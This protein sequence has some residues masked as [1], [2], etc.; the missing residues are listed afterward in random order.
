VVSFETGSWKNRDSIILFCHGLT[1]LLM[2]KQ[3]LAILLLICLLFF[4]T[5]S[6]AQKHT[7]V[8]CRYHQDSIKEDSFNFQLWKI[9]GSHSFG[10]SYAYPGKFVSFNKKKD[11]S[12]TIYDY[13]VKDTTCAFVADG[14]GHEIIAIPGDTM[15]MN[16]NGKERKLV[17]NKY[18]VPWFHNLT[19]EG[20]NR[21]VYS[22]FDS[23]T[24]VAGEFRFSGIHFNKKNDLD[25]FCEEVKG[26][27]NER[28]LFLEQYC[29][30]HNIGN[31][32]KELARNEIWAAYINN[33]LTPLDQNDSLTT[34]DYSKPYREIILKSRFNDPSIYFKTVM[35]GSAAYPFTALVLST[36]RLSRT[37]GDGDF[38][39]LYE[40]IKHD[41][42]DTIRNHLITNHLSCF[43][44]N[45]N[46]IYPS[47]DS[48]LTDF[49]SIC[50]NYKYTH[51]LDSLFSARKE[52]HVKKYSFEEALSSQIVDTK[53]QLSDVKHLFKSK[54]LLIIC[55]ASWCGPCIREIPSEKKL[56]SIYGDKVDFIYLSFDKSKKL[57]QDKLQTLS[58]N[59]GN[60]Y[61]LTNYFN[62][63]F[64]GFYNIHSIPYYLLYDKNGNKVET[65]DLR[66]SNDEFKSILDKLIH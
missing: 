55:W 43:L 32:Y 9:L 61:L 56:Q 21:F 36:N 52:L 62:S 11:Y 22:L 50:K 15:I 8:I 20:K 44:R 4:C 41:Y 39:S 26:E 23:L 53:D 48:L 30:R 18:P 16:I 17:N 45:P 29:K 46:L 14:F 1:K 65:K 33:L 7:I 49:K 47:F 42:S 54:P 58:I 31:P 66:P 12:E 51:Y 19:Y 2:L 40:T 28:I 25:K 34:N 38:K 64:A 37:K 24:F 60:N 6:F 10:E 57:W 27:Y 3:K 35:Y 59:D 13:M 5:N 63:D